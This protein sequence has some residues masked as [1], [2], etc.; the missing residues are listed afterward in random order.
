MF[1]AAYK[2]KNKFLQKSF[3]T[4]FL[5][6]FTLFSSTQKSFSSNSKNLT[7]FA[8]QNMMLVLTRIARI[9]SQQNNVV[10]SINFNSSLELINDVDAGEPA[11]VFISAHSSLIDTLK[12]KGLV[13]VYNISYIA[14]DKL[15]LVTSKNNPKINP[16]LLNKDI[17]LKEAITILAKNR[18]T[19][20]VDE[21]G[22]SSERY[23][24]ELI[25]S[26]SHRGRL[27]VVNKLQEDRASVLSS[28][29]YNPENYIIVLES[30][31]KNRDDLQIL[32]TNEDNNILY[33]ALVIAGNNMGS[34][35]EFLQF[36]K[37]KAAKLELEKS[38]FITE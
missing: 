25:N 31:I 10:I 12:Q 4:L 33:Q 6:L 36:L 27:H 22:S 35:R 18:S 14:R 16:K 24:M 34:A 28:I 30:Q 8:E 7:I 17:K 13:D 1:R 11:D 2:M 32:A 38:G 37:S 15:A 20:I 26:I 3:I 23:S 5:A 29:N 9:Y 21:K 19:L